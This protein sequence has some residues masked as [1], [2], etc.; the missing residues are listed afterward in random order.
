MEMNNRNYIVIEGVIGAGKT[1]LVH[2]LAEKYSGAVLLEQFADNPFL[3]KFYKDQERYSFPLEMS[4]LASR[5]KQLTKD[6]SEAQTFPL[7][8]DY[9][10]NKSR[11]FAQA[12]LNNDEFALYD[13]VFNI[14]YSG[15]PKP[16][17]YVFLQQSTPQLLQNIKKRGREYEGEID[18]NYLNKLKNGYM[19]TLKKEKGF[20]VVII[21]TEKLD[22]V[23][24]AGHF[25]LLSN[26]IMHGTF[27]NGLQEITL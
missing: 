3:P 15:L 1:S 16:D 4:F 7:F 22:F 9:Y 18:A 23:E 14:I 26:T 2:A 21:N 13:Q 8:A 10:F 12:T 20:P 17:I 11:I 27:K 24:Q 6:F 19:E 25:E 5:Y